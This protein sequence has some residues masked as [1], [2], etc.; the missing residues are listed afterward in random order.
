MT[1]A[2]DM[3]KRLFKPIRAGWKAPLCQ[4]MAL[5]CLAGGLA[6][7]PALAQETVCARV[8]IEIKQ[9]LTLER[10]AFDA[11]MKINN[12]TDTGVIEN[13]KVVV[14]V[15]DESGVPV[16]IS[17][18]PNDLSAKFY[19]R[20]SSKENISDVDGSGTV[21]AKTTSTI[22]WLLIPAPGAAGNNPLGKKYLVGATLSYKYGGETQTMDVSPDVI[23]VKPLPLLTLDYFLTQDV[24]AD[25][26]LTAEIEPVEPFT[27][28]VRVKNNG[29]ATA[30]NLKIDSAQ[31]KI[32]ENNQGLLIN[33]TLT[34]SYVN[35]APVQ[36]TLL[37]DFGDIAASTAKMGRWNMETTL[38]GKFAE[39]TA[40]FT[41][42]DELGG[43]MTSILQATNAHF[44]LR[45][46]RVDLTGRDLVRDFL[47]KDGDVI[48]VYESDGPDT[49]VTDRSAV[50]TLTP[51]TGSNGNATY[52]LSFPAT[53]GFAYVRL[54]DPY[55]GTKVLGKIIRSDAKQ[56]AS[57]N[58]WLSKTRNEQSKQ[59]E[60]WVNFFDVNSTGLYDSEFQAP[61]VAA[62]PPVMQYVPDHVTKE[63]KQVSFLVEASS[64]DGRPLVLSAVPLPVGASFTQQAKDPA[65]PGL[66]RAIFDWTPA[67]GSAGNYLINYTATDGSLTT[68]MAASIKVEVDAPPP[69]PGTPTIEAPLSGALV[70]QLKPSLSVQVSASPLDPTTK[71]QFEVYAD[72]AETQ[73]VA[74][75]F[76]DKVVAGATNDGVSVAVPTT[77]QLPINLTDNT[78]YWWRA[79]AFD[80][81]LYSPWVNGHFFVNTFNDP[82]D[83]FNLSNPVPNAEVASLTPQLTWTN[84]L[85]KDGDLITYDVTVYK[86]ATLS[87]I[88]ARGTELAPDVAGSTGWIV[89]LPLSNHSTYYWGVVAK[90]ALGAQTPTPIRPFVVNTGNTA[91]S[92][93]VL[94]SPAV[95]GQ[96]I[97]ANTMLRI[98]N[99]LDA[100]NDLITYVFEIDTVNTFD[101]ADKKNSGQIIQGGD[102]T[103][104]MANSLVEN[105]RYWWRV[106]AQ[107][108]R[109]ESAWVVGDFMMN[110]VNDPPPA[111]SVKNPSDGAW[112]ATQ[113]PSLEANPVLDPEGQAV[114]YQFEIYKDAGLTQKAADGTSANTALIVPFPLADKTTYWWRVRAMDSQNAS[115]GWSLPAV[116]YIST[117]PYQNPSIAVITPA[118]PV[119]P[120]MVATDGGVRKQVTIRWEGVD[121]NIEPTV[122]LYYG[123][124]RT[125]FVGNLIV[126][127][128]R[129]SAGMQLGSYVWDVTALAPGAYY[130]YAVIYDAKGVGK[131]YAP[132]AVVIP[133]VQQSG[134]IVVTAGNHLITSESGRTA[135]FSIRLGHP[136]VADV[137]LPLSTSNMREGEV[138]PAGLIFT[139]K[140]WAA[141]QTVTATG[142][143]DCARDGS[144]V[145]QVLSGKAQT[146][147][148]DYIGLT[149]KSVS[150]LNLGK[151]D[152]A[153]T[154]N[155]P[156]IHICGLS[157]VSENKVDAGA[158][159]YKLKA[160][161]TN[162]GNAV[163]AVTARINKFPRGIINLVDDTL[164]F[165]AVGSGETAKT[166]DTVTLR[167]RVPI[168]AGLFKLGAGFMWNVEVRP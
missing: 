128:L 151:V 1:K 81:S 133:T 77:W 121:P 104:W 159:E 105:K 123:T 36:N 46:V 61:P 71:L 85:D 84:S 42:A 25:D 143:N 146:V 110:A 28:G 45:D 37:I 26:P 66:V 107:D 9:E 11:Q 150:V 98:Q 43:A 135:A 140:N 91:P 23:T 130:V 51:T 40:R 147:D 35:D 70:A 39:F 153:K 74:S 166:N 17:S 122:A 6:V 53:A 56:L 120:E 158:W 87:E 139:P 144:Q 68:S 5:L 62:R 48:R 119:M 47:A 38:A 157:L 131:S 114:R 129:Q 155:N 154:T 97:Q 102:G 92:T 44:L 16:L 54:P 113:Q 60:Y 41:H 148:P 4:A 168:P 167:S 55:N 116:L 73:I 125:G 30:K 101:S 29:L 136:P 111:P 88:V 50:A 79:R 32:I 156:S 152:L 2:D 115:S 126:D 12:T 160:E 3:S 14:K 10:Q 19:V 72:E 21:N 161:L 108:G 106:K 165:G 149:G 94:L 93:P 67:K 117:S 13:V 96:T 22:D 18:D 100:E 27:L 33:F 142:Q 34:G 162:T 163:A 57:E 20:I 65:A 8:K 112:S 78:R 64:P 141:N 124:D 145:Y 69:G 90:D 76:V 58:V 86:D 137:V 52:R 31:P 127:S 103:S 118:T 83:S 109:A 82:P 138:S 75:A 134:S 99:S 89:P 7:V 49:E 59:W 63:T 132:G 15:T 24:W 164:L 80:G 95:G